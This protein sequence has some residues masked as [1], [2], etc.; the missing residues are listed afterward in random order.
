M[1]RSTMWEK[2]VVCKILV[3]KPDDKGSLGEPTRILEVNTKNY[4]K[5]RIGGRRK[6][7]LSFVNAMMHLVIP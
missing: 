1:I 7:C 4:I 6:I 3:G 5:D 2:R